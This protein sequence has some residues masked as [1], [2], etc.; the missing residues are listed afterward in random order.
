[1]IGY[2][3]PKTAEINGKEWDIRSDYRAALDIITVMNDPELDDQERGMIVM[4]IFYP[5]FQ[6][7]NPS[8]Y[9]EA[10]D[11]VYWFI[12][13]GETDT[14]QQKKPRLIDWEQDF[15]LIVSPVNRV[16][17]YEIRSTDYLHW[18]SFLSAY[19]EIG[20]CLFSQVVGIRSKK[21]K[22]KKLDK[23]DEEFY[24]ANRKLIDFQQVYTQDEQDLMDQWLV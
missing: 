16:I 13:G 12:G 2:D 22:H 19:Y 15:P 24:R 14:E 11:Y 18:W 17:G 5:D 21:A 9:Q 4:T 7:M 20:D 1:M 8:D 10:I 6:D 23:S 3:L